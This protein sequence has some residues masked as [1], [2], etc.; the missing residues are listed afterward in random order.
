MH[1]SVRLSAPSHSQMV[2]LD[3]VTGECDLFGEAGVAVDLEALLCLVVFVELDS[4][5][6]RF[7]GWGA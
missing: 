3:L 2:M 4:L 1:A 6:Q 7:W 5:G